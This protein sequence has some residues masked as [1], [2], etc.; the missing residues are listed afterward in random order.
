VAV[1]NPD[2]AV[3]D[4]AK[5]RDYLLSALHPIGRFKAA[6]FGS[7]GYT[8]DHADEL[9]HDLRTHIRSARVARVEGTPYGHKYMVRGRIV[10]PAGRVAE[11]ISVWIVLT[12]EDYP[13]FV[14]AYPGGA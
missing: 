13:R 6:F 4:P 8:S 2:R 14:T 5:L 9:A 12:G 11:L 7:L 10:G 3:I 1:P